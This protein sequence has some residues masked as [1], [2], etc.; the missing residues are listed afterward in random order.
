MKAEKGTIS[1]S[2]VNET[3]AL[4]LARGLDASQLAE[5]AGIAAP[6]LA[7]PKSRVSSAQYGALWSGI[8]RALDDEFFG[9]DSHRMKSG[10]FVAMTQAALTARTGAQALARAVGFMRLVLDDLGAQIEMHAQ[11]VR[12]RFVEREGTKPPAMFAYATYFIVVYGLL[13]W[14]VGRRIPLIQARFRC[15]APPAAHEYQ[16]MFCDDMAFD[17]A[18]SYVD[19]SPVFLEL[20]V[21]Q[22][23]RSAKPF[24]RDAPASFI[25][26]YRNPGSLAARVRKTL[27]ALPMAAWPAADQM[28]AR[29]NVAE[30][31]MRRHLKQE[32]HTYQSIKD[33]LRRDIAIGELQKSRRTIADIAASVG[34]AEPSA[35]HRAFR[36]WTGMRPTDYRPARADLTRRAESD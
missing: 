32:G 15:A 35:F 29:L 27:R 8:A 11:R 24:L 18:E 3:L 12:L 1:V 4:A 16:L 13:C 22:T 5:A 26:K 36:K 10:S 2:L 30:A 14:L 33:D 17:Q 31:T 34:F 6:M 21:I 28:A 19:L 20:P 23:P 25:V 9:Q 7:S